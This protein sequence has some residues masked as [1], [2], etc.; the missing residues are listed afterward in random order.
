MEKQQIGVHSSSIMVDVEEATV[1]VN[2]EKGFPLSMSGNWSKC[3][4]SNTSQLPQRGE[5]HDQLNG[6]PCLV[7]ALVSAFG[8]GV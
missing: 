1:V 8:I 2:P 7:S 6:H 4:P 3:L 5:L